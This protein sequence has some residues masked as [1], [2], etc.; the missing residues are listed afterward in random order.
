MIAGSRRRVAER[1]LSRAFP[2]LPPPARRRLCR[3]SFQHVGLI[4]AELA[5]L[6]AR[7]LSVTL[8]RIDIDG[9]ERLDAVMKAHG[10]ALVL[11]GHLGNWELLPPACRLTPY[12]LTIV[13]RPL[14]SPILDAVVVRLREKA[15]VEI[16][17]KRNAVRPVLRAL[18][19]GRLVGILL[20][21]NAARH[22]SVFVPFFGHTASTSK[23]IAVLAV[24]TGAPVLPIFTWRE[25]PGHHRVSVQAP[26]MIPDGARGDEAVR[27][28]AARCT[29]VI[30]GAIR[31]HPAQWLWM[32]DRWRTRP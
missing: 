19:A 11:T 2:E 16:V 7:P 32:H 8:A 18:S 9:A 12:S 17:D 31:R 10:R 23:G 21:Q 25:G 3:E 15:G 1:N 4:V 14:D 26:M 28:L 13:A 30:E 6:L 20:D 22:E 27:E 5:N 24:R 29:E